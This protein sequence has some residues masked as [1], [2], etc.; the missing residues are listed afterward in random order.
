MHCGRARRAAASAVI[1]GRHEA[2]GAALGRV[3]GRAADGAVGPSNKRARRGERLVIVKMQRRVYGSHAPQAPAVGRVR[4][5]T[6]VSRRSGG[7]LVVAGLDK[8][9]EVQKHL[10][11]HIRAKDLHARRQT[12]RARVCAR[13]PILVQQL[14][15][16]RA[17]RARE[18]RA[19]VEAGKARGDGRGEAVRRAVLG[20]AVR[21]EAARH[22]RVARACRAAHAVEIRGQ[23]ASKAGLDRR[24]RRLRRAQQR[25]LGLDADAHGAHFVPVAVGQLQ[26]PAAHVFPRAQHRPERNGRLAAWHRRA[27]RALCRAQPDDDVERGR[28]TAAE[29]ADN[30]VHRVRARHELELLAQP[31]VQPALARLDGRR[32]NG[33]AYGRQFN[34]HR[35]EC[36]ARRGE[37]VVGERELVDA[38]HDGVLQAL[39]A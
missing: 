33:P 14:P 7:R 12:D 22:E 37:Q 17:L 18:G 8:G 21:P 27:A 4:V 10:V 32:A 16:E 2:Y 19:T 30:V 20:K 11:L 26:Q 29:R 39:V 6:E 23:R 24:S 28:V 38:Q 3:G 31:D 15:D 5:R 1:A 25:A 13:P 35:R 36:A 34:L 9:G